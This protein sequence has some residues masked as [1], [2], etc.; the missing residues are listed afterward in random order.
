[1]TGLP[2][3]PADRSQ[4]AVPAAV[5]SVVGTAGRS[6]LGADGGY[7]CSADEMTR[8]AESDRMLP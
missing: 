5:V 1:M 2:D 3:R 4:L 6:R 7:N 8:T